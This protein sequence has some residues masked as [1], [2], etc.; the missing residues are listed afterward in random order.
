[1]NSEV[2]LTAQEVADW[3]NENP[4]SVIRWG[5]EGTALF[6][7]PI[8][9]KDGTFKWN[10]EHVQKWLENMENQNV[11]LIQHPEEKEKESK[12]HPPSHR[13]VMETDAEDIA[14]T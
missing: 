2:L 4:Q 5:K 9:Q 6:P 12:L 11:G 1:M 10:R 8:R 13:R 3:I 14:G 7:Y